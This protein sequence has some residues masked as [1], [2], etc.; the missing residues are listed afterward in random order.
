[1]SRNF[2]GIEFSIAT[3]LMC[4]LNMV[5]GKRFKVFGQQMGSLAEAYD[6][7]DDNFVIRGKN[8]K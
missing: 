6:D 5:N 8:V 2:Y 7:D 1:M 4:I 3:D